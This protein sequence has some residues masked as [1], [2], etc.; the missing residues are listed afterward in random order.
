VDHDPRREVVLDRD[1]L[2]AG[3]RQTFTE[4]ALVR[5]TPNRVVLEVD[6]RHPGYL[7]LTDAWY[8]GWSATLDGRG[9]QIL[10]ADLAFRAVALPEPGK[11]KIVFAY[12]PVGLR[13]GIVVSGLTVT[14]L[15]ARSWSGRRRRSAS[16]SRQV[17]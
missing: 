12:Q 7:V 14:G 17:R 4:A 15:V 9:V 3:R 16:S 5:D 8:P 2:L 1:V 13:I 10:L 11:H 6:I